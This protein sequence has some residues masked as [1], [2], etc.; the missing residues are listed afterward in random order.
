MAETWKDD[1]SGKVKKDALI[2]QQRVD[3]NYKAD[4]EN[5]DRK[6]KFQFFKD[7]YLETVFGIVAAVV[8]LGFYFYQSMTKPQTMLYVAVADDLLSDQKVDELEEAV[9]TYLGMDGK[10]Q[11]VEINTSY[12]STNPRLSKQLQDYIYAGSC[13]VVIA[14]KEGFESWAQVGYFFEPDTSDVVSFYKECEEEDRLYC[15]IHDGA[16]IRGEKEPD[17]TL[18]N[19]GVSVLECEKYKELEGDAETAYAG[20]VN[21]TKHAEEAA[22]FL[23]FLLDDEA[24]AG[25]EHPDFKTP[26]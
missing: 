21:S 5:L 3:T 16:E 8:I 15:Q 26:S 13:D 22:A 18:Y 20:I 23:Q 11:V 12:S 1:D 6:G 25:D 17:E 19:F 7:Y 24:K 9:E 2:Y 14:S 10:R 4:Y